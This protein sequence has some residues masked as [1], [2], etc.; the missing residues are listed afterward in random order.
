VFAASLTAF[1]PACDPSGR[2]LETAVAM[3]LTVIECAPDPEPE[4]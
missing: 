3:G 4:D 2:A 1:D